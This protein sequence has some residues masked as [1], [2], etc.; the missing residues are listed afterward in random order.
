MFCMNS[1]EVKNII[2]ILLEK[3][4]IH[5]LSKFFSYLRG[6]ERVLSHLQI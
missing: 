5:N 1:V 6:S 2:C 4:I 3:E